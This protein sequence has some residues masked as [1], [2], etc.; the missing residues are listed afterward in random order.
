MDILRREFRSPSPLPSGLSTGKVKRFRNSSVTNTSLLSCHAS[1]GVASLIPSK[2]RWNRKIHK[3][4]LFIE[5][6]F[7]LCACGNLKPISLLWVT[8]HLNR[9]FRGTQRQ[10]L[11]NICSDD[12][13]R[14]RIFGRFVVKFLASLPLLGFSSTFKNGIIAHF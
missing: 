14:S 2:Q 6:I 1:E 13:V 11:E 10:F 4:E 7:A 12:D 9:L 8:V 5:W 3:L